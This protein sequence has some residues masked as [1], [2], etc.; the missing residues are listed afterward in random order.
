MYA[1]LCMLMCLRVFVRERDWWKEG[2]E[3]ALPPT[4]QAFRPHGWLPKTL[5]VII[6]TSIHLFRGDAVNINTTQ[7]H[8]NAGWRHATFYTYTLCSCVKRP[9]HVNGWHT[10]IQ[11][12]PTCWHACIYRL[13]LTC[14]NSSKRAHTQRYKHDYILIQMHTTGSCNCIPVLPSTAE[15]RLGNCPETHMGNKWKNNQKTTLHN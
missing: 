13:K 9:Y 5:L 8:Q 11:I 14:T 15:G 2:Q 1:C 3:G 12:W 10:C 6:S 4:Q 7:Q